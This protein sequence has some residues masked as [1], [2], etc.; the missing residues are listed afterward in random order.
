MF[1]V[2][3]FMIYDFAIIG[4]GP[5]GYSAAMYAGRLGLK[6]IIFAPSPGGL[7]ITTETVENY[8][9]FKSIG[10]YELFQ[11][12]QEHAREYKIKE[13]MNEV[14]WVSRRDEALPRLYEIKT[15]KEKAQARAIL[16]ATGSKYRKLSL[17]EADKF[18]NKGIH[19]CA[20]CDG[21]AYKGKI[22]AVVGSGNAAAKEALE[23]AQHAKQVYIIIRG[24]RLKAEPVN[25]ERIKVNAKIEIIL[26]ANIIKIIGQ[27]RIQ[28]VELDRHYQNSGKLKIDGI[29]VAIGQIP[30]SKLAAQLGVELNQKGEIA[31][32]RRMETNISGVFAAGDVTDTEFKQLITGCAEG[33]T[34]AYGAFN[35]IQD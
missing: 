20:L 4:G 5:T 7:I 10:G 8:P 9:G 6:T 25:Q 34:A 29:F 22:V 21:F 27:E 1:H 3:C 35:F 23:L 30:K 26:R 31:V 2:S 18:E 13:K 24:D 32:N 33:V 12:I 17:P 14:L 28:G 19:Y 15:K 11:R 16:F